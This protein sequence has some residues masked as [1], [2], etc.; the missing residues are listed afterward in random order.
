MLIPMNRLKA[1]ERRNTLTL[2]QLAEE[3]EKIGKESQ[4][5]LRCSQCLS[6]MEKRERNVGP[7]VFNTDTCSRCDLV[8]FDKGEIA[9]WQ[10]MYETSA[11]GAEAN[12]FRRRLKE[13]SDEEK[14]AFEQRLKRLPKRYLAKE[15]G[16]ALLIRTLF[17]VL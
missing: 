4:Q 10:V 8:W 17:H 16:G 11:K 3:I 12:R 1:I 13:M 9:V 14:E 15:I 5:S 6:V 7:L 2:E